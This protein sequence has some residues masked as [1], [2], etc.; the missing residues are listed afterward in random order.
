MFVSGHFWLDFFRLFFLVESQDGYI[1]P[2]TLVELDEDL[3]A[4]LHSEVIQ[5]ARP[6]D[7]K[8]AEETGYPAPMDLAAV[9]AM[10]CT[11]LGFCPNGFSFEI[12]PKLGIADCG[13]PECGIADVPRFAMLQC[14]DFPKKKKS[15]SKYNPVR[16]FQAVLYQQK[17]QLREELEFL[18]D[19]SRDARQNNFRLLG[20]QNEVHL[21][22]DAALDD[23]CEVGLLQFYWFG[24]LL[25]LKHFGKVCSILLNIPFGPSLSHS[26][27]SSAFL[28]TKLVP[29]AIDLL[30]CT[31][32]FQ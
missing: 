28:V 4:F 29:L 11:D 1:K 13:V 20:H 10:L 32:P 27:E 18:R 17:K 9:P 7:R 8:Q 6:P 15:L 24:S 2:G 25:I 21:V 16:F 12:K 30:C 23:L 19:A 26:N 14:I 5:C 22:P 31:P 3:A